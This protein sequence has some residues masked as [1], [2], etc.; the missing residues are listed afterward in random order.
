VAA[1]RLQGRQSTGLSIL[2]V[3]APRICVNHGRTG[4]ARVRPG[5]REALAAALPRGVLG[6]TKLDR[7]A[8]TLPDARDSVEGLATHGVRLPLGRSVHDPAD[9]VNRQ[10]STL[11]VAATRSMPAQ[12]TAKGLPRH[13]EQQKH[14]WHRDH[15]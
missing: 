12:A 9:P 15:Q 3:D 1:A 10:L 7:L 13:Q 14:S 2:G 6:V 11:I 8:R 4:T 5:L